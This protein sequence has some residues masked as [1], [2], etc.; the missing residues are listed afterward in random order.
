MPIY[1]L[2]GIQGSGKST[3][4]VFFIYCESLGYRMW[5]F[6]D[7]GQP[8]RGEP[9]KVLCND[10]LNFPYTHFT[11]EFFLENLANDALTD[12][13]IFWDEMYQLADARSSPSKINKLFSYFF[14]QTRKRGVDL[15]VSTHRLGNIDV[16]LRHA[17]DVRGAC[18]YYEEKP[19]KMCKG[20]GGQNGQPCKRCLG[21]GKVGLAEGLFLDRRKRRRLTWPIFAN[22]YWHLFDTRERI[23]L[24]AK[25]LQ[26]ID[27]VEVG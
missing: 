15:Y 6:D 20:S 10:H 27:T 2:E 7:K 12:C 18:K 9:R 14:V 21:Y 5:E 22:E 17:I 1:S 13:V 11:T 19:C 4:G 25:M 23:P 16:R 26:G 24:Y 3:L 8:V